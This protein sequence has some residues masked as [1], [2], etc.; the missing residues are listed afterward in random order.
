[1]ARTRNNQGFTLLEIVISITILALMALMISR[2]FSTSTQAVDRG[3]GQALLDETARLLLDVIEQDISQALIR[4]NVAFRV[5]SV[6]EGDALYFISTGVRRRQEGLPRDTGPMRLR[7]SYKRTTGT[8]L[9]RY[10]IAESVTGST[11]NDT[12]GNERLIYQSDYYYPASP[13]PAPCS[14]FISIQGGEWKDAGISAYTEFIEGTGGVHDH[15]SI[16]FLDFVI[17]GD[18]NS[19]FTADAPPDPDDMPRFVDVALGL[20]TSKEMEQAIRIDTAQ[21]DAEANDFLHNKERVYTRRI[22]MRNKGID[23]LNL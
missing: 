21:G 15:A 5:H 12:D 18:A 17:N 23:H 11:E 14:D 10:V 20:V 4:T 19:N 3:K 8:D 6:V 1:M 16:T 9:N 2:I 13:N 22:F 7:T